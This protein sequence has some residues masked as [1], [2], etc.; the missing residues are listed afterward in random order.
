MNQSPVQRGRWIVTIGAV[1][2]MVS[3]F[4]QWWR[5]GGGPNELPATTGVGISDTTGFILFLAAV[6]TLLLITLPYAASGPVALDRPMSYLILLLIGVVAFVA[7]IATMIQSGL[8]LYTGQTPPI[9]PLRGPGFWLA[10]VGLVILA[11]GVFELWEARRE[12]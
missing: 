5:L 3:D 4:M 12:M 1:V 7:R 6:A 11:R 8:L 9:Q 2:V 10:A